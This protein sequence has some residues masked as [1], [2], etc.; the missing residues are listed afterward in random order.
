MNVT[1]YGKGKFADVIKLRIFR[2]ES[3][4]GY[5]VS[6]KCNHSVLW[7]ASKGGLTTEAEGNVTTEAANSDPGGRGQ[8]PK[9]AKN[10][11]LEGKYKNMVS[12]L[13]LPERVG[14]D[15]FFDIGQWDSFQTSVRNLRE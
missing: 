11:A 6:L 3:I 2:W 4:L 8:D 1:L 10:A 5:Q 14:T 12:L 15:H 9:N 7:E 13:E